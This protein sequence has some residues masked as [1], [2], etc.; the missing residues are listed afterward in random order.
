MKIQHSYTSPV[1]V[2]Y[3]QLKGGDV[4]RFEGEIWV[5]HGDTNSAVAGMFRAKDGIYKAASNVLL[6][7]VDAVLVVK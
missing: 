2:M 4:V 7:P 3:A 1:K 5:M 6:E